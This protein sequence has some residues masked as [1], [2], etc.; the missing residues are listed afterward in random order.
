MSTGSAG[1]LCAM[2]ARTSVGGVLDRLPLGP[3]A[4]APR[5]MDR[6]GAALDM[7]PRR[8]LGQ[9]DDC[10][11]LAGGG[12]KARKLEFL[13]AEALAQGCDTLVTGG[14][15]QRAIDSSARFDRPVAGAPG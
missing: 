1:R 8:A 12:N 3:P 11:G 2:V 9:A 7:E 14:G 10:T 4:D 5:A 15:R 13:C 6:L